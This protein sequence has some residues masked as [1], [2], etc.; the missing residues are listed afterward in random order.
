M[1]LEFQCDCSCASVPLAHPWEHTVGSGHATLALRADWQEHLTRAHLEL[2][3]RHVRFHGLLSDDMGTLVWHD[4]KFLYSFL[5]ADRI[6]DFLLSIGMKPFIELSF[7]PL[8]LASG[9]T[10]VFHYRGNVTPPKDYVQWRALVSKLVGHWV[11]R[12]GVREV[13]QWPLEIWNEP[14]L[15]AFWTGDQA[16]YFNLYRHAVDAIKGVDASLKVG[17]PAT[18][19]NAW[20]ADFLEFCDSNGL[21]ADFVSTHY[22]PTDAFGDIGTDTVTQLEHAPRDVMLRRAEEAR[23]HAKARPL[24]YTEWNI[25]SKPRDSL[26]DEAFAA[27]CAV[28]IVMTLQHLVDAYSFWTFSDIFEELYFPS[29]PFHGG[30][31]LMNLHGIAKPVYR[32]FQLLHRLGKERLPVRGEHPTVSAWVARDGRELTALFTNHAMPRHAIATEK[33]RLRLVNAGTARGAVMSC[34]DAAHANPYAVWKELGSPEYLSDRQVDTLH[35]ASMLAET[36]YAIQG[37]DG[38]IEF[39]VTLPPQSV[40][41]VRIGLQDTSSASATDSRSRR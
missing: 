36:P 14:N 27:A 35:A 22:Y 19:Q 20:L 30:F 38:A 1:I 39:E 21:A 18:A 9:D 41:S 7:M 34:I 16:A 17:G 32:A 11:D 6:V 3:F 23:R 40:V 8:I 33:V 24:Y 10:T 12:Y 15:S 26:H 28:Y 2:G 4:D 31:G 5:N 29:V 37:C 25:T 13:A